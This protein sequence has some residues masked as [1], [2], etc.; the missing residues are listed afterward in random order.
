MSL[1]LLVSGV[2]S[3][4]VLGYIVRYDTPR[5]TYLQ[6]EGHGANLAQF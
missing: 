2:W 6:K 3:V 1:E 5:S 4:Y